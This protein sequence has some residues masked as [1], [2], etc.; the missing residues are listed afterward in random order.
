MRS[1]LILPRE[2][3]GGGR[4][5]RP[6]FSYPAPAPPPSS[7]FPIHAAP[8]CRVQ[9]PAPIRFSLLANL[10]SLGGLGAI[11]FSVASVISVVKMNTIK[12]MKYIFPPHFF[13]AARPHHKIPQPKKNFP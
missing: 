4:H 12:G 1:L 2:R 11:P 6:Q 13:R 8:Q 10:A 3:G 5:Q 9:T 7:S